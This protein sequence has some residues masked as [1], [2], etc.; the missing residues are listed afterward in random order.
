[1]TLRKPRWSC[2]WTEISFLA[3]RQVCN[4]RGSFPVPVARRQTPLILRAPTCPRLY[5]AEPTPSNTGTMADHRLACGAGEILAL[6]RALVDGIASDAGIAGQGLRADW[7]KKAA[8]DLRANPGAGLVFAGEGQPVEVHHLVFQLNRDL[9]NLGRAVHFRPSAQARVVSQTDSLRELAAAMRAG[10]V[11]LLVQF[12]GNPVY[13]APADL[14]F[15]GAMGKVKRNVHLGL[16]YNETAQYCQWHAPQAHYLEGWGDARA[17]DGTLSIIQPLIE[18]LYQGK[19]RVRVTRH[20]AAEAVHARVV[21]HRA[22]ALDSDTSTGRRKHDE[23]DAKVVAEGRSGESLAQ[24]HSRRPGGL[25][26]VVFRGSTRFLP[27]RRPLRS[28]P[29]PLRWKS[30]SSRTRP[31]GMVVFP[32][33]AGSRKRP[34]PFRN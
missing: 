1:M 8:Q 25:H 9:G 5:V 30:S 18:P 20:P 15:A 6:A 16:F 29:I 19:N 3:I 22:R 11:D 32:T 10:Q 14:D 4:T 21:R 13:D 12:G 24:N 34:S 7:L 26:H 33:T 27:S 31:C 2:R 23:R 28:R 17:F